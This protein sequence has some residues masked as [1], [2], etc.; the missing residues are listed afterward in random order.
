MRTMSANPKHAEIREL[1]EAARSEPVTVTEIKW[2]KSGF[3]LLAVCE[4]KGKKHTV[5]LDSL[6]FIQPYPEGFEW[7]EAYLLWRGDAGDEEEEDEE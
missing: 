5:S 7:I 1:I 3:G 2:P 4:R 6:E